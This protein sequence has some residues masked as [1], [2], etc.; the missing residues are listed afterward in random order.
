V[1]GALSV[2]MLSHLAST[3]APTGAERS[4]VVLAN[5]LAVRGH[6]VRLALP[7]RWVLERNL[8]PGIE[9]VE[10][11]TRMCWLTHH[12]PDPAWK[13]AARWLR[14]AAPDAG[15]R[16]LERWLRTVRPDVVHVNC[17]PHVRGAAAAHRAGYPVVWH[18]REILPPGP[19]RRWFARQLASCADSIVAVSEAVAAWLREEGLGARVTV[20][21]NGVDPPASPKSRE[22]ARRAL[23]LPVDG[24]VAGLFGQLLPHK[25]VIETIEAAAGALR[26]APALRLLAAG[27][28]PPEFLAR[29]D[30]AGRRSLDSRFHRLAGIADPSD[31]FAAADI[32]VLATRTPDPLPRAVLEAMA[33]GRP[34]AAF[35]SGGTA[36][37]VVDGQ[38]GLLA[39]GGDVA[40]LGRAIGRLASDADLRAKMGAA[41]SSRVRESFSIATHVQRMEAVLRKVVEAD[42]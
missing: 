38:T 13:V 14:F 37:M 24:V 17:L 16:R 1:S 33:W 21:P 31:L 9:F 30:D 8:V 40:G 35:R 11:P 26:E 15:A 36:E 32:V 3:R 29:I 42:T 20:V 4:L 22:A 27:D 28:G 41:G 34:V 39:D 10:I 7:A 23:G 25:G 18:L 12:E 19:R 2:A 6:R 5:G